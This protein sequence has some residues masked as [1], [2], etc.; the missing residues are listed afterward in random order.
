METKAVVEQDA[1]NRAW[2]TFLQGLLIDVVVAIAA[3]LLVWLP[4]ADLTSA[5]GWTIFGVSVGKTVLTAVASYVM[6][7]FKPPTGDV[8]EVGMRDLVLVALVIAVICILV[9][10]F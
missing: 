6:R 8:G 2:R 9:L 3:A 4:D 7:K 10:L 1:Q 5:Q